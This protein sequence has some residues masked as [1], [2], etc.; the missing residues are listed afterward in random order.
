MRTINMTFSD[1]DFEKLKNKK[2]NYEKTSKERVSWENFVF[3]L[4]IGK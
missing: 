4:V 1:E 3:K 2:E